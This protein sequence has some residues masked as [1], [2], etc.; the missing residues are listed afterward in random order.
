MLDPKAWP[1]LVAEINS[2]LRSRLSEPG[3]VVDT[4]EILDELLN[5]RHCGRY[6]SSQYELEKNMS[7][8]CI[9]IAGELSYV[10]AAAIRAMEGRGEI[11]VAGGGGTEAAAAAYLDYMGFDKA[12]K[13]GFG[14]PKTLVA[15]PLSTLLSA[16]LEPGDMKWPHVE[17]LISQS[18]KALRHELAPL[19][20]VGI[21]IAVEEAV[22]S[23]LIDFGV[24]GAKVDDFRP[25][26]REEI[27]FDE[28]LK[29]SKTFTPMDRSATRSC[30]SAI[31]SAGN[32]AA[33]SGK[34]DDA[35]NN[36]LLVFSTLKAISSLSAAVVPST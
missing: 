18:V 22:K 27:L 23:A 14:F 19:A 28:Y 16:P 2:L 21:R 20:L 35:H 7:E 29:S 11:R 24:D 10:A 34:A 12:V 25:Y 32:H 3:A 8:E 15:T 9:L 5:R 17:S 30:L 36:E 13:Q 31:R 33:H 6:A 4:V 26:G 1:A